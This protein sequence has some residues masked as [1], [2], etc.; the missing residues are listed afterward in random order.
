VA[1]CIY[2]CFSVWLQRLALDGCIPSFF[3]ATNKWRNTNHNIGISFFLICASLV[4]VLQGDISQLS[5][6][7]ALAFLSV[8]VCNHTPLT[9]NSSRVP[10]PLFTFSLSS[11]IS[12]L[13]SLYISLSLS[14]SPPLHISRPAL[15][16][17]NKT[18]SLLLH[19]LQFYFCLLLCCCYVQT[20]FAIC[21]VLIKVKRSKIRRSVFASSWHIACGFLLVTWGLLGTIMRSITI[22]GFFVRRHAH[23]NQGMPECSAS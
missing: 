1:G 21:C 2:I 22:F 11:H 5:G 3:A 4:V 18:K 15:P 12:L 7:F 9:C 20:L 6:I 23:I 16:T 10:T 17:V 14:L 8:M 13:L 19:A